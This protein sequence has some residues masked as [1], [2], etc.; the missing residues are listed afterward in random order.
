M[1]SGQS[2][3]V[4]SHAQRYT[5]AS[6]KCSS[7]LLC[8]SHQL[9]ILPDNSTKMT[10]T[11]QRD[12][13]SR[14]NSLSELEEGLPLYAELQYTE[15]LPDLLPRA[16]ASPMEVSDFLAYL[17]TNSRD[18]STEGAR[19]LAALWTKGTGQELRSYSPAMYFEIFGKEDG[20]IVYREVHLALH[21]E[22]STGSW[23]KCGPC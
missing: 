2:Q 23:Y 4:H 10:A 3:I 18:M 12:A 6:H 11:V 13:S 7:V 16:K 5:F 14:K 1:S 19:R 22:K 15:A 8:L 17:L 21:R 9:T 20:W